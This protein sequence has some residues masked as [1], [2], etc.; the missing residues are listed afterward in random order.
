MKKI[1]ITILILCLIVSFGFAQQ[2]AGA[3]KSGGLVQLQQGA[4]E[5]DIIFW[6]GSTWTRLSVGANGTFLSSNGTTVSWAVVDQDS[7]WT[8]ASIDTLN[9]LLFS[10]ATDGQQNN[11]LSDSLEVA[12]TVELANGNR[13]IIGTVPVDNAGNRLYILGSGGAVAGSDLNDTGDTFIIEDDKSFLINL[14]SSVAGGLMVSDGTRGRGTLQYLHSADSWT[15]FGNGISNEYVIYAPAAFTWNNDNIDVDYLFKV[16]DVGSGFRID[17]NTG[18]HTQQTYIIRQHVKIEG[19]TDESAT[20]WF[21][22]TTT[23]EAGS[24]DGGMYSVKVHLTAGEAIAVGATNISSVSLIAHW[25][26]AMQGAGTGANS[27]V[28]EISESAAA[29][30]GTGAITAVTITVT[31]TSEFVQQVLL[32]VNTSGGTFDGFA[33]VELVYSDFTT[34]PTIN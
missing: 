15:F 25:T 3:H 21:T 10:D 18:S 23:D 29:D 12:G 16:D 32:N 34:P 33:I 31:E 6:N 17:G 30:L 20:N 4:A 19:A 7:S 22:I 13:L 24:N 2:K 26:R 8:S 27:A 11:R 9:T 1:L 14:I 5:G 28:S